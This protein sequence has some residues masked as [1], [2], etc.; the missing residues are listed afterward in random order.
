MAAVKARCKFWVASVKRMS[1]ALEEVELI[2][3]YDKDDPEDTRFAEATPSGGLKFTLTNPH[4]V[5]TFNP[6]DVFYVDLTP[7]EAAVP[8]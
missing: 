7:V 2:T 5:G 3:L 6:G 1:S 4:L 8:A